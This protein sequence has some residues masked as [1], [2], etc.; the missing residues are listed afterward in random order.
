MT[1]M[2]YQNDLPF[3]EPE[4]HNQ[5]SD[6]GFSGKAVGEF[7]IIYFFMAKVWQLFGKS[8][9]SY[10]LVQLIILFIGSF[11][12]FRMLI[13]ILGNAIRAGFISMIVVTSPMFIFY[14]PNFLPDAPALAFTFMAWFF[15]YH[16]LQSRKTFLLWIASLFLF[17][18][19]TLKITTGTSFIAIGFWV[20][21]ESIF[22]KPENRIFKFNFVQHMPFLISLIATFGWYWYVNYYNDLHEGHFSVFGIWPIWR[23]N[24]EQI[25]KV[26]DGVRKIY[27]RE[28]FWPPLQYATIV[29]WVFMLF[30]I[31]KIKP[32][33]GFLL[34]VMPIASLAIYALWFQLLEAHDYYLIS[35]MQSFI[36]IWIIFFIYLKD[37]RFWN[38]WTACIPLIAVFAV[39]ANNGRYRHSERYM[40]WMNEHYKLHL[41]ALTEIE[42]YFQKWGI[43]PNDKVISIPDNSMV[44]SLYYMNRIGYINFGNDFSREETFRKRINQGAKYLIVIDTTVLKQPAVQKFATDTIGRYRNVI[45]YRL[46]PPVTIRRL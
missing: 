29:V 4:I 17:L 45:A 38:H 37:K 13:P 9:W 31:R 8:E 2:Y 1:Q 30:K 18:A 14:G 27:F 36:I 26:V 7:P 34:I 21:F 22:I 12:L 20:L 46:K 23:L 19:L 6:H 11:L 42:P 24:S 5:N 33:Y 10:R 41:E 16:F 44:G 3:F 28:Y 25:M 39:L 35:Q 40:G 32:F 43:E 15:I